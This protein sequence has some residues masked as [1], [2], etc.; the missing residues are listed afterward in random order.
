MEVEIGGFDELFGLGVGWVEGYCGE[1]GGGDKG[2]DCFYYV[3][4][5]WVGVD[6]DVGV[7]WEG[8]EVG[9]DGLEGGEV[10]GLFD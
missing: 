2:G 3:D 8:D 6:V 5:C 1:G 10:F 4:Y 9:G 7:G